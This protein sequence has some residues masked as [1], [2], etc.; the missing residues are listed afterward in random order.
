MQPDSSLKTVRGA[1]FMIPLAA[2]SGQYKSNICGRQRCTETIFY[3]RSCCYSITL[4][5]T[6]LPPV[7]QAH[8]EMNCFLPAR[9]YEEMFGKYAFR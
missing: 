3:A 7:N 1:A 8:T 4:S 5:C 9:K 2:V 6:I